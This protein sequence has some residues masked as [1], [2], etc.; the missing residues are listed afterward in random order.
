MEVDYLIIGQ[1]LA[2]SLLAWE[3][4]QRNKKVLVVDNGKENASQVAAGLINPVTGM[5]FVK[6]TD[7]DTLLPTANHYYQQ[8]SQYFQQA[9]YIEKP[10]LRLLRNSKEL[11]TCQKRLCQSEY[12]NYLGGINHSDSNLKSEYGLLK[13]K[14][15]GY[16]LTQPLL[17]TLRKYFI[18]KNAYLKAELNYKEITLP[19]LKWREIKAKKI[20]FCEGHLASKN[21]W[22]SWL[23]FQLVKGEI[24][25]ASSIHQISQNIL[26]YGQWFIPLDSHTFKTG[27]TFDRDNLNTSITQN[28]QSFLIQSLQQAYPRLTI[29]HIIE[30]QAGIRPTT[31]DKQP[32]IGQHPKH[33]ELIIFNGFGAKGSLQIP[34][35]SQ[36]LAD[37]LLNNQ[38]I[39]ATSHILR[40]NSRIAV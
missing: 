36:C 25:T 15:T 19:P 16:L 31:L 32:F 23:P 40:Y 12:Q 30:Q 20:I 14:Q 35:Y 6:S 24:V 26:N 9:F 3:L 13:Q 10:M 11:T 17:A 34:W 28:A 27:A 21:P 29:D 4:C 18:S 1:G 37:N 22:F 5:R 39:S 8:L 7:V 33:P 2:G 38:P